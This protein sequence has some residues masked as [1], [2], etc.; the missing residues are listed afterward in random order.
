MS[1]RILVTGAA[2][3]IGHHAVE[4][5]LQNTDDEIIG[6]ISF[7]HKGCP[8]RLRHLVGHPRFRILYHDLQGPIS[9]QLAHQI[10]PIDYIINIAAESH[11]D[12]SIK[13]PVPF[14]RNNVDVALNAL[15]YARLVRPK[16]FIQISTDEVYGPAEIGVKHTEWFPIIPSN[17]Y[18]ASKAAQEAIAISYW[19]TYGVPVVLTNTMNNFGERQNIEKFVPMVMRC[20]HR[21]EPVKARSP[22][23][24]HGSRFWLHAKN[25]A[26]ALLFLCQLKPATFPES[27]RP[28]RWNIVGDV[29]LVNQDMAHIIAK[30]IGQPLQYTIVEKNVAH[31]PGHDLRYALD[32]KKIAE[33]GW[34]APLDFEE[35]L[36]RM[37]EW[38]L[39][40]LE[41]L[42]KSK[43][44][45]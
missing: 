23:W 16:V 15:E 35:S 13:Y 37:A 41:W 17:P 2:G 12:R 4:H 26:D 19:R 28:S 36:H 33:A 7:R 9:E 43:E 44:L 20:V 40:H 45:N 32:G 11:V 31:R 14:V 30:V 3:F 27:D 29:E 38:S 1:K 24:E 6:F 42:I 34:K 22:E 25:H 39:A 21:Q 10:G 18:S 5:L 8:E